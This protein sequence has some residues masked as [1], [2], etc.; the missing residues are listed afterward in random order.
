MSDDDW[1]PSEFAVRDQWNDSAIGAEELAETN[2]EFDRFIAS[3]KAEAWDDGYKSGSWDMSMLRA[4][5]L[6]FQDIITNPHRKP[7]S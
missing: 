5:E 4:G 2:A 6:R 1:T 3:I 7:S